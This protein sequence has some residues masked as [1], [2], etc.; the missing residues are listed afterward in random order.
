MNHNKY[1][2]F[3]II[4]AIQIVVA[5]TFPLYGYDLTFTDIPLEIETFYFL[6][7]ADKKWIIK[8][9]YTSAN[10][11]HFWLEDITTGEICEIFPESIPLNE[12]DYLC[13]NAITEKSLTTQSKESHDF[14]LNVENYLNRF[15][16]ASGNIK[17]NSSEEYYRKQLLLDKVKPCLNL[18]D[19]ETIFFEGKCWN[20]FKNYPY[21][22]SFFYNYCLYINERKRIPE[23]EYFLNSAPDNILFRYTK[24]IV[25]G[26][27]PEFEDKLLHGD[28][29]SLY[30]KLISL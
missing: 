25:G 16:M 7:G 26:S 21:V 6:T 22:S 8:K 14:M 18:I 4:E 30:K 24:N 13:K 23:Y 28:Y 17:F 10:K 5:S 15:C 29:S 2:F 11:V 27:F 19:W 9:A 1:T 12:I 20:L 3:N